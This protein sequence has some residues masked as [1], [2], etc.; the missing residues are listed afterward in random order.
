MDGL[1]FTLS[2]LTPDVSARVGGEILPN[3]LGVFTST[4]PSRK[5]T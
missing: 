1:T 4:I 3:L 5:P 2:D